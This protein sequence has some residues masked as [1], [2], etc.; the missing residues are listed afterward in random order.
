MR[1]RAGRTLLT[2]DDWT[3]AALGALAAGGPDAVA[4]DRLARGL[5]ASRGSFY[6]HFA[7]REALLV[8]ALERWE[9]EHTDELIP[10][11]EAV[12]D[13]VERLRELFR[14]VYDQPV[15]ALE[16]TLAFAATHPLVAPVFARVTERRVG[17]LERLFAD[18]GLPAGDARER[19]WLAY[20]FYVGHHQL[21]RTAVRPPAGLEATVALLSSRP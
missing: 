1:T 10:E 15:D 17:F 19:A 7:D 4:V 3:A 11:I 2:P 8:A 14:L 5:G 18:L 6:W 20:G 12:A 9:R 16:V 13:P 21:R